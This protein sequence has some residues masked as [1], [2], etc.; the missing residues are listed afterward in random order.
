MGGI[1]ATDDDNL[2][3]SVERAFGSMA[4]KG[5]LCSSL[6]AVFRRYPLYLLQPFGH[7]I[8]KICQ[9]LVGRVAAEEFHDL[10]FVR[11]RQQ[12]MDFILFFG[13][14]FQGV[15]DRFQRVAVFPGELLA[16]LFH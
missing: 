11:M 6:S 4:E 13:H 8:G 15:Q 5:V 2:I 16:K 7:G 9:F 10:V 1:P 3:N 14:G 12:K